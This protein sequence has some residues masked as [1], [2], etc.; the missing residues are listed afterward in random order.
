MPENENILIDARNVNVEYETYHALHDIMLSIKAGELVAIIGPNGCGKS[1]TMRTIN[2]LLKLSTGSLTVGG[3]DVTKVSL[4]E[5]A[6]MCSNIPTEFP[7][8]FNLSVYEVVMLGSYPHRQSMWWETEKDEE[9]VRA[10][11]EMYGMSHLADRDITQLSSGERQRTLIAKAYVQQPR[12][13][14]VDEPTAHLDIRYTLEVMQYFKDLIKREKDMA[15]VIA[16]HDLNAVAKYCDRIVMMKKGHIIACG[17]PEEV[18]TPENIETVYGVKADVIKHDGAL[19]MIAKYPIPEHNKEF[20]E[21]DLAC[22]LVLENNAQS[23]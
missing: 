14:L 20:E 23:G 4:E 5:M 19:V 10:A 16:A 13:M 22:S 11:L 9:V 17:T 3:L 1:T 12:I 8:D 7:P 6:K 2:G 18:M 15:I 21:T